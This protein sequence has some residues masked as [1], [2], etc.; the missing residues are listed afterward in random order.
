MGDA[1]TIGCVLVTHLRARVELA[2]RAEL[3]GRAGV[4]VERSG[5]RPVVIDCLPAAEAVEVGM[6]LE[7]ALSLQ[8][9][10]VVLE[11]DE[12]HYA[13]E[14]ERLLAALDEVSDRVEGA[15]ADGQLGVAYVGLDGLEAMYGGETPMLD[16]L[17]HAVPSHFEPR[18]GIGAGKFPALAA[19][20]TRGSPGVSRVG[21]DTRAAAAFL[22]PHS[23]NLLPPALVPSELVD[24]LHRLGLH[25][26]GEV[27]GQEM[28]ALLDRF[29]HEGRRAWEL[30]RGIDARPLRPRVAEESITETVTLPA[31]SASLELLRVA[32]DTLL[33]R[34][35]AQPRMQGRYAGSATL[36]CKLEDAPT[37]ASTWMKEFHFKSRV[38]SWQR[39]AEI[40]KARLEIEHPQAPVE[41]MTVTLANLSGASGVQLS[42]FPDL[43]ADRERRLL[44]TERQLQ[45]RLK[46]RHALHRMVE[47]APWH[48]A[49]EMRTV[50]VSIDPAASAD[51]RPV[52][53]P[54]VVEVREGPAQ[55]PRAVR[56]GAEWQEVSSI[57]DRW[58]FDLWWR[59][60]PMHR[61]YYRISQAD[62]QQ[63]TIFR[64]QREARWYQQTA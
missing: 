40:V 53:A 36:V 46:G 20:R 54:S 16:A 26:M 32:V 7:Q 18:I 3:W 43:R 49:P 9:D 57:E 27:A 28:H 29:G 24:D 35:F 14:F 58:S 23:I 60:T 22:A 19:A 12:P 30:C 61:S 6:T 31:A 63:V 21:R 11:A 45:A 55:E 51:M 8:P 37:E 52:S 41:A 50:Q 39:A 64:D 13:R 59:P 2:R 34:V 4:I 47:V 38:G 48:P 25:T 62:G 56:I 15:E 42:L 1:A 44:E 17:L 10:A 5:S 33:T